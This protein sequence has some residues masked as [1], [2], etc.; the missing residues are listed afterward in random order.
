MDNA[1]VEIADWARAH[2][3]ADGLEIK[4]LHPRL[5]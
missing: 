4:R 3:I 1:F 2:H 5:A